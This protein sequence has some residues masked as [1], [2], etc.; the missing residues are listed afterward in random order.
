[1]GTMLHQRRVQRHQL[2]LRRRGRQLL[3][4]QAGD[5]LFLL[6]DVPLALRNVAVRHVEIGAGVMR[7]PVMLTSISAAVHAI[8]TEAFGERPYRLRSVATI[9]AIGTGFWK[10]RAD[11]NRSGMA[12]TS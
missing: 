5:E 7:H 12:A 2:R 1:M 4:T 9:L 3:Q 10:W 8:G 6:H 11:W